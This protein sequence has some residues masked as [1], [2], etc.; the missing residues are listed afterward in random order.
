MEY[1]INRPQIVPRSRVDTPTPATARSRCTASQWDSPLEKAGGPYPYSRR[2]SL[3]ADGAWLEGRV[4]RH[5]NLPAGRHRAADCGTGITAGRPLSFQLLYSSGH[6]SMD[7]QEAAIQS[8]EE[9]GGIKLTL[10]SEPFNTLVPTVRRP[11]PPSHPAASCSWQL[12]DEGYIPYRCTR[13][14]PACSTPAASTTTAVTPARRGQPHRCHRVRLKHPGVL[15]Y[16]DYTAEQLP[17]LWL[18]NATTWSTRAAWTASRR[19]TRF[20][21]PEPRGL[22]LHQVR[23]DLTC[24]AGRARPSRSS[25]A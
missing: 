7:E 5:V 6:A 12:V 2:G 19:S 8:S 3:A 23:Q 20:R 13:R 18:P 10:K 1:L 9:Q 25:S 16:E 21:R 11:A 15:P 17:W 14:A 22:V 24:C 4:Q